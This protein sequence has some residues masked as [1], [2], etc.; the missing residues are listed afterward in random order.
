[1]RR[2]AVLVLSSAISTAAA[3]QSRVFTHADTLRGSNTPERAWW[4]ATFYVDPYVA[5]AIA[6]SSI[7]GANGTC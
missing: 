3:A 1:M 4:D 5:A 2:L 6:D 7:V